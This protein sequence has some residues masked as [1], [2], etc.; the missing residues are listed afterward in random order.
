MHNNQRVEVSGTTMEYRGKPEII[1][2]STNQVKV[3]GGN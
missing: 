1:L 2:E 3:V